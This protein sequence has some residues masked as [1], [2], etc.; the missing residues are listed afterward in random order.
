M[1]T[2][3]TI[4]ILVLAVLLAGCASPAG[5]DNAGGFAAA[6]AAPRR[7][8]FWDRD[9]APAPIPPQPAEATLP[10]SAKAEATPK[11]PAAQ[12]EVLTASVDSFQPVQPTIAVMPSPGPRVG[13]P[14]G[15]LI[16][17][18]DT[19]SHAFS[20]VY[21]RPDYGIIQIDKAMPG[22]VRLNQPFT[23]EIR[24]TNLTDQM[25]TD[26][27]LAETLSKAFAFKSAE[28]AASAQDN[29][30][31]WQIDSLGPKASKS[32]RISGIASGARQ[33]EHCTAVT[34][35][36]RNCAVVQVVEPTLHMV[37]TV[38]TEALLCEP[39]PVEFRITNT[40]TGTAQD[41]QIIDTLPPGM[42]TVDGKDK[43]VLDVGSLL[44][45]ESR[46]FAV[47][48]RA[49]RVGTFTNKAV[50]TSVAGVAAE[51]ETTLINVRQPILK[52]TKSGPQRQ[53]LGRPIS[54]EI[55]VLNKG[56]GPARETIVEDLIPP[57][58]TAVEATAGAQF[59]ASKLVWELGTLEPNTSKKVQVS[60]TPMKEGE[61]VATATAS[62]YCAEMVTDS[63][64]TVVAGIA[65][66]RVEVVDLE[67]P[68]AVG[69]TTTY[70]ITV[71]NEGSA[72]DRN[73]RVACT[74]DDRLQYISS[75]GA[76]AA[77][78]VGRVVTFAPLASL[79]TRGKATWRV[80]V[81]GVRAGDA[82]LKVVMHT[83]SLTLPVED[84]EATHVFQQQSGS[85]TTPGTAR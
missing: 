69:E 3:M 44:A 12:P 41:V 49:T 35:T 66:P 28:P 5:D 23:Y 16:S 85:S 18:V 14:G 9:L 58:V 57:G 84:T 1:K 52:I 82:R 62:A 22:E 68:I 64:K 83:E 19:T 27:V 46:Q 63:T 50:A 26:I 75:A 60:Y 67:D 80:V 61:V 2:V 21:P 33:L 8:S 59:S 78:V 54:Y 47:K 36:A 40:G 65:A 4:S 71:I 13:M 20:M 37:K 77:S 43:V 30:L 55:T 11:A 32:I 7:S 73:V 39:I 45:G 53:Y 70:V 34:Y 72:P 17:I 10:P 15:D 51:S 31:V 24:L 56:D 29:K 81:R 79:E 48:L 76:T 42:Q 6:G 25:L 38:P 74:L